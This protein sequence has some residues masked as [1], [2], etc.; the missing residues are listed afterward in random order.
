MIFGPSAL[1][2]RSKIDKKTFP[3]RSK[4]KQKF[5][6]HLDP[7]FDAS[8]KPTWLPRPSQNPPKIDQNSMK[9]RPKHHSYFLRS[10]WSQ[11]GAIL[12]QLLGHLVPT[13]PNLEPTWA[14]HGPNMAPKWRMER[15][16]RS[17]FGGSC[18]AL[19]G[20]LGAPWGS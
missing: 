1:Q 8:W 17:L 13:W 15:D 7:I 5:G 10:S 2:L 4:M 18:G 19:G 9:N 20:V 16:M 3:D 12:V 14:Q 6:Q 11:C